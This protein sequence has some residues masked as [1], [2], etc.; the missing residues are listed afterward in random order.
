MSLDDHAFIDDQDRPFGWGICSVC[1]EDAD[2]DDY[3]EA[4]R[5]SI[6]TRC[7]VKALAARKSA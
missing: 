1:G 6:C 3:N 7:R 4:T 2:E 5:Q